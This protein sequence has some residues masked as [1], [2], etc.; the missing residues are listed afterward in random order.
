[1]GVATN[2]YQFIE[3]FLEERQIKICGKIICD[4]SCYPIESDCAQW[5]S[6]HV[7]SNKHRM[8]KEGANADPVHRWPMS[9]VPVQL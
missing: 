1:M 2:G 8:L 9:N 6:H 4:Q 3:L 5:N 7:S